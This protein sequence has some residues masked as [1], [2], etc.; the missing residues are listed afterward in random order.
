MARLVKIEDSEIK[1]KKF[2]VKHIRSI[3]SLLGSIQSVD[4]KDF[5]L[6]IADVIAEKF[7][8]IIELLASATSATSEEIEDL[9]LEGMLELATAL[10]EE[11]KGF[12]DKLSPMATVAAEG[13]VNLS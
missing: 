4:G 6:L 1:V 12:F 5:R 8:D 3:A 10:Y 2:K 9:S 13:E 11:N 7:D